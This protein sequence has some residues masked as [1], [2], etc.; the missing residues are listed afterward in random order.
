MAYLPESAALT[1]AQAEPS[2]E[3]RRSLIERVAASEQFSRSA[4][5][6]DLLLYVGR[7]SLKEG[8]PDIHEQEIGVRVF[9]RPSSY[10]RSQDNIVRV[11]ATGLR[12]RVDAYFASVGAQEPLVFEIP[13]GAYKPVFRWRPQAAEPPT[14]AP[15]ESEQPACPAVADSPPARR[16]LLML[17]HA[18][19]ALLSVVLIFACLS[20]WR[21]NR[22]MW[23]SI[24][25]WEN[26]PAVSAFWSGFLDPRRE[27]DLVLPDDSASVI[28]DLTKTPVNLD[29]YLNRGFMRRIQSSPGLGADR[30]YDVN[31]IFSHNLIT[32]GSVRAAQE[33]ARE[34]PPGYPHY[35]TLARNFTADQLPRDNVVL[36]GGVKSL[37]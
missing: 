34:I 30:K 28:E 2:I 15:E 32:F 5:L 25:P 9:G 37:P 17:E 14:S 18:A 10:D 16:H 12:K 19:W 11:N 35:L 27:T 6:R 3:Q 13:R 26:Q 23:A 31:Q 4:R 22:E 8:C 20:L 21:K 33:V 1:G 24:Q 36:I 29:D 7:Q